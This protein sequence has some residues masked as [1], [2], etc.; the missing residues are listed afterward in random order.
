[1]DLV[2]LMLFPSI[3][4]ATQDARATPVSRQMTDREIVAQSM[5]FLL[6][7]YETTSAVLAFLARVLAENPDVQSRLHKEIDDAIGKVICSLSLSLLLRFI[8]IIIIVLLFIFHIS[9]ITML[10]FCLSVC[11][12][13]VS[14]NLLLYK[15][16]TYG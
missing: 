15:C 5:T 12:S 10:S 9:T 2:Q 3:P 4:R 6:A 7:G 14:V 16:H 8:F 11:P 13:S 1:M